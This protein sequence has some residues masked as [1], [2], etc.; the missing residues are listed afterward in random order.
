M[1]SAEGKYSLYRQGS[2]GWSTL[3]NEEFQEQDVWGIL[4]RSKELK[5]SNS[6]S[7]RESS[8]MVSRRRPT[9]SR[10]IP[11]AT[12]SNSGTEPKIIQQSAPVNIPDWSKIY[13]SSSKKPSNTDSRLDD[14]G[15]SDGVMNNSWDSDEEEEDDGSVVPPH[16]W[17][18][19]K[20]ARSQITSFSVCEGVGRTLKGRDLSNV[21]NAVLTKTGFLE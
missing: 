4:G 17:I 20:L 15:N 16:E 2:S 9:S 10:M 7:Y 13:G 18:A 5:K 11:K 3:R 1:S 6:D 12:S 8:S 14:H 19:R 21:R